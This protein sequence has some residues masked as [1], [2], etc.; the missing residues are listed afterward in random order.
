MTKTLNFT[1]TIGYNKLF[2]K[3]ELRDPGPLV[4]NIIVN[5]CSTPVLLY[6]CTVVR[7]DA[8]KK[9]ETEETIGFLSH[10]YYWWHFKEGRPGSLGP[11]LAT[12]MV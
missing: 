8:K 4:V 2:G 9:T 7:D 6:A 12:P 10:F 5:C 3:V 11:L 1:R